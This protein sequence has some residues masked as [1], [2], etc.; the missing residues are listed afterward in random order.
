MD[1]SACPPLISL[2]KSYRG[3]RVVTTFKPAA[4][5]FNGSNRINTADASE[6][7]LESGKWKVESGKAGSARRVKQ[8]GHQW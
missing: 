2:A 5:A 3:K 4:P 6:S 8:L 1:T 7:R